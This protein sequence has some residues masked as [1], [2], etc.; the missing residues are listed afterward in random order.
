MR[1]SIFTDWVPGSPYAQTVFD[2][3]AV[4][5]IEAQGV[6]I[7]DDSNTGQAEPPL[8]HLY[9][10]LQEAEI[11]AELVNQKSLEHLPL[12]RLK[13]LHRSQQRRKYSPPV[14]ISDQ[15]AR[16]VG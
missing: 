15:Q 3:N 10:G 14:N 9:S 5:L 11:A 8:D 2:S 7:G 16:C 1:R 13:Q 4:F 12:G 6:K